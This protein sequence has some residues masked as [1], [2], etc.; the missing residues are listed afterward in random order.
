[1]I[2]NNYWTIVILVMIGIGVRTYKKEKYSGGFVGLEIWLNIL[3]ASL[4]ASW[5]CL[6]LFL[7]GSKHERIEYENTT[8]IIA[9]SDYSGN[10]SSGNMFLLIGSSSSPDTYN[11]RYATKTNEVIKI[12]SL[13][14]SDKVG[15]IEDGNCK[16]I[17]RGYSGKITLNILGR[18][19][20]NGDID[21]TV[22]TVESYEFHIPKGS[23]TND[24][25]ID[26]K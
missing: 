15:F 13:E 25:N 22:N 10:K 1:M 8:E 23:I 26:L 21:E 16:L 7:C 5:V 24:I 6:M 11:I 18:L 17:E 19:L 20:F 12:N 2:I 9:L 14:M 4:I 3:M